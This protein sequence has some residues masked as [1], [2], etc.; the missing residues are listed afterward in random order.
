[1]ISPDMQ[2]VIR[3]RV[4]D[5]R[6]SQWN[7][8]DI[9]H[10]ACGAALKQAESQQQEATPQLLAAIEEATRQEMKKEG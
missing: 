8:E 2:A 7:G 9:F 10:S 3:E 1:M 4:K 6:A 5:M